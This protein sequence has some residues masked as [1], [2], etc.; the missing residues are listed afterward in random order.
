MANHLLVQE[1]FDLERGVTRLLGTYRSVYTRTGVAPVSEKPES[2][3]PGRS[4]PHTLRSVGITK[5]CHQ[6]RNSL[7]VLRRV[8]GMRGVLS[9]N[10][11]HLV[12]VLEN[13]QHV[14]R[15]G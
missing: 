3:S 8:D 14:D 10:H 15:L 5:I 2:D 9:R 7:Q 13:S 11:P 4:V 12:P 6:F 1:H